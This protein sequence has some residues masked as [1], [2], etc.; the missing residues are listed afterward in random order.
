M[1]AKMGYADVTNHIISPKILDL[2][3]SKIFLMHGFARLYLNNKWIKVTPTFN[4]SLCEKMRVKP[5]DFD[6]ENDSM[7]Q[8]YNMEGNKHMEYLQYHDDFEDVPYKY[9]TDLYLTNYPKLCEAGSHI[10]FDFYKDLQ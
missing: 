3:G 1:L 5:L 7:F 8:E 9:L 2:L 10:S 6:G 4:A